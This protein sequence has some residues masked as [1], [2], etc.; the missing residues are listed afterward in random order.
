MQTRITAH[1]DRAR[2]EVEFGL[3]VQVGGKWAVVCDKGKPVR[4]TTEH[5]AEDERKK[6]RAIRSVWVSA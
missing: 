6:L 2:D 4:F 3:L 1:Y 5:E